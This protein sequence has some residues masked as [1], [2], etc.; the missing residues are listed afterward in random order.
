MGFSLLGV[1]FDVVGTVTDPKFALKP[2]RSWLLVAITTWITLILMPMSIYQAMGLRTLSCMVM[3]GFWC[4]T[5]MPISFPT[6][7]ADFP[8]QYEYIEEELQSDA[9]QMRRSDW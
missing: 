7:D 9:A 3:F 6:N 1:G 8:G 2:H 5:V 4:S